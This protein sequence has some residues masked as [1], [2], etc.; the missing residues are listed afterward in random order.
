MIRRFLR[1][2]AVVLALV[3]PAALQAQ[4]SVVVLGGVSA[5]VGRLGDISSIGYN[6]SAGVD[7]GATALP[8]GLRFEAGYNSFGFKNTPTSAQGDVRIITG[9]A[10]AIFNVGTTKDAPYLIAGLG[11][12]NRNYSY[13]NS[14]ISSSSRTALGINGGGGLRFPLSGFSTFFEARYHVML[15]NTADGTNYQFI[16]VTFGIA[17]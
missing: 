7:V 10:N 13:S 3:A 5:P 8:V 11:V 12:Y 1:H 4:M 16:P 15:G 6:V 17:F 9:T 2:G 14:S